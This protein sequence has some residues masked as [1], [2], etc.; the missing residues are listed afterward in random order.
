MP[1]DKQVLMEDV[2]IVYRNF[3][4]A[5]TQYNRAGDRN[6]HVILEPEVA[7]VMEA[8][9]W[10]IKWPK[11]REDGETRN[12]SLP[13]SLSYKGRPPSIYM[14]TS[15]GRTALDEDSCEL[16]DWA[17]I[18]MTDLIINPY[19]WVVND[20]TGIK[21]YLSSLYVTIQ[22]SPLDLKYGDLPD[23]NARP[24]EEE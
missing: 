17:D 13:V 14:I 12:P 1:N 7:Q 22:E 15:R 3:A 8:E 6:F 2:R 16:L 19:A 20:K 9:G 23:A 10:N 4:G 18:V 5:E 21:A 11:E 24:T